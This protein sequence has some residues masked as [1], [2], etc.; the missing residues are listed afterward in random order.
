MLTWKLKVFTLTFIDSWGDDNGEAAVDTG[1]DF[2]S[3]SFAAIELLLPMASLRRRPSILDVG[4]TL[5]GVILSL[6]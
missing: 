4:T 1:I 3:E 2:D 5:S 6:S